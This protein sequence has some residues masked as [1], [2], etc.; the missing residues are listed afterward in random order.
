MGDGLIVYVYTLR[1]FRGSVVD[2]NNLH[3]EE[4][5]LILFNDFNFNTNWCQ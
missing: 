5:M 1:T 2:Q 4:E 3:D